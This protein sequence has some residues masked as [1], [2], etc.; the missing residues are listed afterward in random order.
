MIKHATVVRIELIKIEPSSVFFA[1][2]CPCHL[3]KCRLDRRFLAG[4]FTIIMRLKISTIQA[5]HLLSFIIHKRK[6]KKKKKQKNEKKD[7]FLLLFK[8]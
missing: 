4:T 1:A 3:A 7:K 2:A 5:I 6:K 8:P